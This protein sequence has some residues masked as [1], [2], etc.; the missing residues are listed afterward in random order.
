MESHTSVA[1]INTLDACICPR[2]QDSQWKY[3]IPCASI[4]NDLSFLFVVML[5]DGVI[6]SLFSPKVIHNFIALYFG[7]MYCFISKALKNYFI[8]LYLYQE[9]GS[10]YPFLFLLCHIS[11]QANLPCLSVIYS[12]LMITL[13]EFLS[14]LH[15]YT[16]IRQS[17][18]KKV[19]WGSPSKTGFRISHIYRNRTQEV[20]FLRLSPTTHQGFTINGGILVWMAVKVPKCRPCVQLHF[21]CCFHTSS[22][23]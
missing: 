5:Q 22:K 2:Q 4:W 21:C 23:S 11:Y 9:E 16:V 15:I 19:Q 7:R 6:R 3:C 12:E 13:Q 1:R 8:S 20:F 10:N 18:G 17:A 14:V